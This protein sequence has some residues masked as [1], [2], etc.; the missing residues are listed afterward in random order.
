MKRVFIDMDNVLVDFQSGLDQMS[1]EIKAEYAG[2][3]DEIPGLFAKMKPMEGAIEA[4]HELQKQYDLFILSTAPWKNPSAWSDKVEWVTKYLDDV[5]H[6]RLIISHRKDLCQGDYLIDD[7]GKNGTCEFAG[8]WIEFGSEQFPDWESV[9]QYLLSKE[10]KQSLDDLLNE[11]GRTSLLTHEE[12]L[13]LFKAVQE[14]GTDSEEMRKLEKANMRFVFSVAIQY[15]KQGLT[16]EELI[17]AGTEGLRKGAMKYNFEADYKFI[18]YAIW[19]IRQSII[20]TIES[21]KK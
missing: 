5:F 1:D 2:R 20:Q 12:E 10:K 18:A 15:Q 7:R 9:L 6:K 16:L 13:E 14:K 17:E 19:W 4:V 11:I 3:L 21:K 8:E